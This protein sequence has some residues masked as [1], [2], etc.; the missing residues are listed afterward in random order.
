MAN[1]VC[2]NGVSNML[3]N[4]AFLMIYTECQ[5]YRIVTTEITLWRSIVES[6][7]GIYVLC[8]KQQN[9][10]ND[11]NVTCVMAV[12]IMQHGKFNQ[13]LSLF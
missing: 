1:F 2:C 9:E 3:C 7:M 13:V 12:I 10:N 8:Q 5:C 6:F 11:P 4:Y